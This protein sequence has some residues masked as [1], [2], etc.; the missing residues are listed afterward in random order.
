MTYDFETPASR[1]GNGNMK[2][3]MSAGL[4]QDAVMLAG[5]EMDYPTAPCIRRA[6]AAFAQNGL[7]GF[8]LPDDA[9]RQSIVDWA[10]MARSWTITSE[11]IVPTMG[12]IFGLSTALRAFTQPGDG[13]V[14]QHPSYYRFD[15]AIRRNGRRVVSNPM[16]EENGVYSID[17][18]A[19]EAAFSMDDVKMMVLC[20]PHNPTAKVFALTDLQRIAALAAAYHVIIFSDE[21]FAETAQ[22][23]FDVIPYA[24]VDPEWGITSTSLGKTFNFTGVNQA[25][26]V[27]PDPQLRESYRKQQDV[28]HFGSIDPFFYTALRAAYTP[29]GLDWVHQMNAHTRANDALL[30]SAL[31]QQMPRLSLSPLE[32]SFVVWMDCRRLGLSEETLVSFFEQEALLFADPGAEYGPGGEGFMRLNLAA[33]SSWIHKVIANLS[34]AYEAR[35]FL[36]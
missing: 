34:R 29:E 32:G 25:N 33:P 9:Y 26:L 13:I 14:I 22:P 31:M 12:T 30:R 17:F 10:R 27:I 11:Q 23:G 3:G 16:Q 20:N 19:L 8:T 1:I 21:I 24:S 6:V 36:F 18:D 5:A 28:D 4:P 7:Y 35:G 2:G 15:R